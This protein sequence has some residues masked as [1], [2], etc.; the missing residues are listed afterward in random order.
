MR[1]SSEDLEFDAD[2]YAL[3][4]LGTR[5]CIR[6]LRE[7]RESDRRKDQFLATLAHELRNPLA[8]ISNAL[9]LWPRVE[10]DRDEMKQLHEMMERQVQQII[11]LIDDL[12]D[13]SRI[14]RGKIELRKQT[15][16]LTTVLEGA[17]EAI[18]PFIEACNQRLTVSLPGEPILVE[19][20]IAR[21][22]QVF[23]NILHNAA[24]YT[25]RDGC[26]F[27]SASREEAQ[28]VVRIKD[29][30]P[31]IPRHML[32]EVF[33]MFAQVD[34]TLER[35]HGGLG[36][37]LT[38]A[39]NLVQL[40]GGTIEANSEGPGKGS[41]FISSPPGRSALFPK[42]SANGRFTTSAP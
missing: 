7:L 31:G 18:R 12:L 19:G 22:S 29:N 1:H 25:G 14:T 26:I 28:A 40:H 32:S 10:H 21:L 5:C 39:K 17:L 42:T 4:H 9:Q 3:R 36:I 41:E 23:A 13:V 8:P 24:K 33:E 6:L 38:L 37:G 20:D 30:G 16:S 34:Q 35:S 2:D 27:V 15:V 11:R